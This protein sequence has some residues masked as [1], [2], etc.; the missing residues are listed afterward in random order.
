[1]G[2]IEQLNMST[3]T[4]KQFLDMLGDKLLE[5][6]MAPEGS[7]IYEMCRIDNPADL[8]KKFEDRDEDDQVT[9]DKDIEKFEALFQNIVGPS[10]QTTKSNK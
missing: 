7:D 4:P 6:Q 8:V 10:S 1:M 2:L 3:R 9:D 5:I